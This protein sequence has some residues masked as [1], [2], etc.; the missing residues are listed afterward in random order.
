MAKKS[1]S[2]IANLATAPMIYVD[3]LAGILSGPFVTRLTFGVQD[4]H[5][6]DIPRAAVTVVIPTHSFISLIRDMEKT[7]GSDGFQAQVGTA[8]MSVARSISNASTAKTVALKRSTT[9][10]KQG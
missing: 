8:M 1:E 2:G 10:T 6:G 9:K 3:Q 4:E 5:G 7:I